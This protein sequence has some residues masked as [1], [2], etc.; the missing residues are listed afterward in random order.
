MKT[1]PHVS[2]KLKFR[3]SRHCSVQQCPARASGIL[4]KILRCLWGTKQ[5]KI[6]Y[7]VDSAAIMFFHSFVLLVG[8]RNDRCGMYLSGHSLFRYIDVSIE[9]SMATSPLRGQRITESTHFTILT[10]INKSCFLLV[11]GIF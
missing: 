1:C 8:H 9:S 6:I 3:S 10:R 7:C 11:S 4:K 5:L 2:W